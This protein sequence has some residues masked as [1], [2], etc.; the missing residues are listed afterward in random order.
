MRAFEGRELEAE[1]SGGMRC[2]RE[3]VLSR[4]R[5]RRC[6]KARVPSSGPASGGECGGG[7][8]VV[9][10]MG[11]LGG[12]VLFGRGDGAGGGGRAF[13][14]GGGG[15]RVFS[16]MGEAAEGDEFLGEDCE[17]GGEGWE[18]F[19]RRRAG[20]WWVVVGVGS[21]RGRRSGGRWRWE[22]GGGAGC[23]V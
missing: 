17:E 12:G 18:V 16:G 11:G 21:E 6:I 10:G 13:E 14:G 20:D 5:G 1:R 19:V 2:K 7:E 15:L 22:L 8:G 23:C 4:G 9:L 3:K